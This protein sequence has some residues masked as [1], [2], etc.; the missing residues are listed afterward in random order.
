MSKTSENPGVL[1]V[2]FLFS[3][4][5]DLAREFFNTTFFFIFS[6]EWHYLQKRCANN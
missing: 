1:G 6:I 3:I 4:L 2:L 5:E